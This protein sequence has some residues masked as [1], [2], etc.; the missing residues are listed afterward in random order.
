MVEESNGNAR[1]KKPNTPLAETVF[2]TGNLSGPRKA[3]SHH[4][5]ILLT[6]LE[7]SNKKLTR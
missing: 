3:M 5:H 6:M 7:T 4:E 1:L 2:H